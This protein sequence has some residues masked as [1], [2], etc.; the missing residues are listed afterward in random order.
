MVDLANHSDHLLVRG[1]KFQ[2]VLRVGM[3]LPPAPL[4]LVGEA[5]LWGSDEQ[6][7]EIDARVTLQRL[8]LD[9]IWDVLPFLSPCFYLSRLQKAES[10]CCC[11]R[12]FDPIEAIWNS[13][14]DAW[15]SLFCKILATFEH[16][17]VS[18]GLKY[19]A[20]EL[21][22]QLASILPASDSDWPSMHVH[23]EECVLSSAYLSVCLNRSIKIWNW[24]TH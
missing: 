1:G 13:S 17:R 14:S 22:T 7:V 8:M 6:T 5:C 23:E 3:Q 18:T 4:H 21:K 20:I 12:G 16:I 24:G 10:L 9:R 11:Q 15:L 2:H 19:L